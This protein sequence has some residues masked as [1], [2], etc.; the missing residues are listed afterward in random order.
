MLLSVSARAVPDPFLFVL[1]ANQSFHGDIELI[2][3]RRSSALDLDLLVNQSF[4]GNLL[5]L[6]FGH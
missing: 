6:N 4:Q 1:L 5:H 2:I 3:S